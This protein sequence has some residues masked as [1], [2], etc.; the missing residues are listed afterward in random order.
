MSKRALAHYDARTRGLGSSDVQKLRKLE[1]RG[2]RG[3]RQSA[4][5]FGAKDLTHE[6]LDSSKVYE[7]V[8]QRT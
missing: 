2:Q 4:G 7:N 6:K 1:M 5:K 3:T 8:L